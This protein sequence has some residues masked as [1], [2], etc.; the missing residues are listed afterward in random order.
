VFQR[1]SL[2]AGSGAIAGQGGATASGPWMITIAG[3]HMPRGA[4]EV[5]WAAWARPGP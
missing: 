4:R 1:V 3:E 5:Y 2:P